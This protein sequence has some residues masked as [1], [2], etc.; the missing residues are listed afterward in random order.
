MSTRP[1]RTA[2]KGR[3]RAGKRATI[4]LRDAPSSKKESREPQKDSDKTSLLFVCTGNI[5]RSPMAA[6]MAEGILKSRVPGISVKSTGRLTPGRPPTEPMLQVMSKR[7]FDLRS[8]V[9][10]RLD[11]SLDEL[12]DLIIG[13]AR[14]HVREVANHRPDLF[15]RTFT[16][17]ELVRIAEHAGPRIEGEQLLAYLR[18]IGTGRRITSLLGVSPRDDVEDPIGGPIQEYERCAAEL[19]G[20]VAK[21][22]DYLWP[23]SSNFRL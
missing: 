18:R 1:R 3:T 2:L 14:E 6:A 7:G 15:E 20:L 8:H 10:S 4:P 22:A 17:K 23:S 11:S 9:S 5:C 16:L 19:E 12:P 21:L 13:M